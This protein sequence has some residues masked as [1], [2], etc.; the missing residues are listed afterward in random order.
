ME[1]LEALRKAEEQKRKEE[2]VR[3]HRGYMLCSQ[4]C[5]QIEF[6]IFTSKIYITC[7][8]EMIVQHGCTSL[9]FCHSFGKFG[10]Y[11]FNFAELTMYFNARA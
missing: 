5:N 2:E 1:R 11:F 3:Y 10:V 9:H 4:M 6:H 7:F 8:V